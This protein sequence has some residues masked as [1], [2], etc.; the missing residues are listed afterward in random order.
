[1]T[2]SV[3]AVGAG[4]GRRAAPAPGPGAAGAATLTA[5][6]LLALPHRPPDHR[7]AY[8]P[9][10]S[11][12]GELRVPAGAGPHPVVVL[13]H[14]GCWRADF[15]S[16]GSIGPMADALRDDG[17]ASWSIEYRRIHEPG[18]GWPGTYQ[19]VGRAVDRLR[20]LAGPY[21]LDL[22]RVVVVGHSAGGHLAMWAAARTKLPRESALYQ[23]DPLP[24]R[25]VVD[26]DGTP[27]MADGYRSMDGVCGE[28]VVE[29]MVGGTPEAV[30][31]HYAQVSAI[32]MLP[33]GVPQVLVWGALDDQV[34]L[35]LAERYLSA[36]QRAGDRVRLVVEPH[37]GHFEA[38]SPRSAS[39][40]AVRAAVR[41]LLDGRMPSREGAPRTAGRG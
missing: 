33:L 25:G 29:A 23:E 18:A 36:A 41:S 14:G 17:I 28:N 40:P 20:S 15:A 35:S 7:L 30:P 31:Q 6:E 10:S 9:D 38:A 12:Y 11:Q 19:D 34:P 16:A 26:L 13:I 27:D 1:V 24:L 37:A 21:H 22:S 32:E 4:C 2:A 8:G 3:L 39:W 5:Q